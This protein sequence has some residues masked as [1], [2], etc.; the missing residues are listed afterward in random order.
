MN[1]SHI[2]IS[3][4]QN[5]F[6]HLFD[7]QL[8]EKIVAVSS[9][10]KFETNQTIMSI[11]DKIQ[12]IPILLNGSIK[13]MRED[14]EGNEYLL[15]YIERGETCAMTLNCCMSESRSQ[16]IAIAE[17]ESQLIFIPIKKLEEWIVTEPTWCR[18]ILES[19]NTRLMEAIAA[20]DNLA[21]NNMEE[22]L[23]KYLKDK[24]MISGN[25]KIKTTHNNIANDLNSSRVVVSRLVKKLEEDGKIKAFRNAIEVVF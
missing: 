11:G 2:I 18:Y 17:E 16:I 14:E 21:F 1:N 19:Y 20:I 25:P 3:L 12:Y 8:M 13:I 4:L 24:A 22:R 15:Y 5:E 7:L 9:V 6:E 23:Y 10:K